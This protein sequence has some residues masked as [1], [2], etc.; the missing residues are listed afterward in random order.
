MHRIHLLR[1]IFM[2]NWT[3]GCLWEA[4]GEIQFKSFSPNC[5]LIFKKI[6]AVTVQ[7]TGLSRNATYEPGRKLLDKMKIC[8][9]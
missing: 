6:M 2:V 8:H 1:V 7:M 3:T 5:K 4:L 9:P